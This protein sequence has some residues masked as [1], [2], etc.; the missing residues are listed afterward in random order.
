[1]SAK[2]RMRRYTKTLKSAL[3]YCVHMFLQA[4]TCFNE[5]ILPDYDSYEE[6]A[7]NLTTAIFETGNQFQLR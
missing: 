3:S 6:L 7:N 4:H 5:L 2:C 1:M